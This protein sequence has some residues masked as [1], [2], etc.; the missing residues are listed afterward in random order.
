[1][2]SLQFLSLCHFDGTAVIEKSVLIMAEEEINIREELRQCLDSAESMALDGKGDT[3]D[4]CREICAGC[5]LLAEQ[6]LQKDEKTWEISLLAEHFLKYAGHLEGFDGELGFV[7]TVTERMVE[8][9]FDHPRLKLRLLQ[10]RLLVLHRIES[11]A[12]HD[13]GVTEDVESEIG[14]LKRNIARA[15][16][17][18]FQE[19]EQEGHLKKDP[20]CWTWYW[21]RV[22][23][24]V[25]EEVSRRLE[26]VQRGMGFCFAYWAEKKN[27]MKELHGIEWK[28]PSEM[29]PKVL[30]D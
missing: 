22:I 24:S 26:G 1:M 11:L 28:T 20:V 25:E 18:A 21:E 27:V 15:D 30:F 23:D 29:N 13:L 16:R 17:G 19:I 10:F 6:D 12:D 5:V 8:T 14:F 7:N 9:V 2:L 4:L 3:L